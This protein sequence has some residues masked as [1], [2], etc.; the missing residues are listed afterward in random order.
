MPCAWLNIALMHHPG[1]FKVSM[2]PGG[3]AM[4]TLDLQDNKMNVMGETFLAELP[5]IVEKLENDSSVKVIVF[6]SGKKD[7]IAGADIPM[8]AKVSARG[9]DAIVKEVSNACTAFFDKMLAGKPKV[10]AIS[11]ACLGGGAEFAL[12][13][14]YR[15]ATVDATLGF[16]EVMLGLLPGAGGTQRLPQL[17]GIQAALPMLMTG[18]TKKAKSAKSMKLVDMTCE[19]AQLA[20]CAAVVAAD[21]AA[22]KT[23]IPKRGVFKGANAYIEKAI[24]EY[25]FVRDYVFKTAKSQVMKQTQ[26][27]YP[28]PLK[29]IEVL[30]KSLDS[31]SLGKKKGYDYEADGFADLALTPESSGT[32]RRQ[33][34]HRV[35][36]N[37]DRATIALALLCDLFVR[38]LGL[39]AKSRSAALSLFP[40]DSPLFAVSRAD[41]MR[42]RVF[43]GLRPSFSGRLP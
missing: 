42:L 10:A 19:V 31:K 21:I 40:T 32:T 20:D 2:K 16:P 14:H 12:A 28:A 37:I 3:V 43:Q 38:V 29:I 15:I 7:F 4:V 23:K 11:G 30:K 22:G 26:G 35:D 27:N 9:K 6:I 36:G 18:A 5:P 25:S 17:I 41:P 34:S 33:S 13:C 39:G 8:F 24:S 1:S